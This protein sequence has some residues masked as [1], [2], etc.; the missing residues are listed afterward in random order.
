MIIASMIQATNITG[1]IIFVGCAAR[2]T[3]SIGTLIIQAITQRLKL[4]PAANTIAIKVRGKIVAIPPTNE[5]A[6]QRIL[7]LSCMSHQVINFLA[8]PFIR[9]PLAKES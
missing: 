7:F 1:N 5:I 2:F 9:V 8:K 6:S 3:T 4:L